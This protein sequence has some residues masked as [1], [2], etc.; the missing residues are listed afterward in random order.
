MDTGSGCGKAVIEA[1]GLCVHYAGVCALKDVTLSITPGSFVLVGGPSGGGKSTLAHALTGLIPQTVPAELSGCVSIAGLDPRRH[2]LAQIGT[3][4]GLVFQNPASQLF[5]GLVEEEVAFGPRNLGLPSGEIEP[6]VRYALEAIGCAHLQGRQVRCLSGGEQQRVAIAAILAMRPSVLILDEP[7][8]NLD[9]AGGRSLVRVLTRLHRQSGMTLMVI[10]H[11]LSPFTPHADRLICLSD[12]QIIA[13][14]PP[15]ETLA[16]MQPTPD[17]H[18][19]PPRP[20]EDALVAL[21]RITAGYNG[22]PILQDCSL[23]L[24]RGDFAALVGTNGA[25]KTTLARVLAGVLRPRRGRVVW[26]TN[27]RER[28]VGLLQQNPLHQLVCDTVEEEMRFGSPPPGSTGD[29][30]TGEQGTMLAS[31]DLLKLRQRPTSALSVGEQQR[32]ALA[33]TLSPSPPLVILDEP[34]AGQDW[35]H[36]IRVMDFMAELNRAGQTILLITHDRRLVKRYA[37]RVWRLE[38]GRVMSLRR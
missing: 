37:N 8:A 22:H 24:H 21:R 25:G 16:R 7:T 23:T 1:R 12:G 6:R 11:R 19:P 5:N 20:A 33:A 34:T 2:T 3:R 13:D 35:G 9:R 26:H 36:L 15:V 28:R 27:R 31:M 30:M 4:V 18:P 32:V 17:P 29:E 10:E 38:N 14:G